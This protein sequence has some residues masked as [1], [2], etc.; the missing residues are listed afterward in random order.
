MY[1]N[2]WP[3]HIYQSSAQVPALKVKLGRLLAA[4]L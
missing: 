3:L 1:R 2:Y 4:T